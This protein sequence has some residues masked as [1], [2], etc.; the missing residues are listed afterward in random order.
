MKRNWITR[1]RMFTEKMLRAL[2]RVLEVSQVFVAF[3]FYAVFIFM[4]AT[5]KT[6]DVR[7]EFNNPVF[8]T[9]F[10]IITVIAVHSTVMSWRNLKK[11]EQK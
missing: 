9:L 4:I 7:R 3:V 11:R 2:V 5:D 1:T 10:V 6:G 8:I